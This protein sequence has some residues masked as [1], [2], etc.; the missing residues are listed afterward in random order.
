MRLNALWV[1]LLACCF[2]ILLAVPTRGHAQTDSGSDA[3]A[4]RLFEAG[5]V[6]YAAD[7]FEEAVRNF[8]RAYVFSPRYPLF[9]NIGQAE[10]R[11]GH[12]A[13]ALEA[14]E[15]FL[16]QASDDDGRR[17]EV[18]ERVRVLR[19]MGTTVTTIETPA[20]TTPE[21]EPE[22]GSSAPIEPLASSSAS[23][24]EGPGV[25]PWVVLGVGA[26]AAIVG[27]VLMGVGAADAS[28]VTGAADGAR[29]ADLQGPAG[30]ANTEFGVGLTLLAVGVVAMGVGLV[31]AVAG[32]GGSSDA[33]AS[34]RLGPG[35]IALEGSF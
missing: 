27:A 34:L 16:R 24:G 35:G 10:F 29:W 21:P 20:L 22:T 3:E 15:G 1:V 12:D 11:A 32:G 26:A 23:G 6:A 14:F 31:W 33:S 2:S 17:G 25:A 7:D 13:Q 18:Q 4:R 19:A 30:A 28:T 5:R 8:R 9:Y